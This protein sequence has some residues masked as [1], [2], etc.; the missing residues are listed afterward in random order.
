MAGTQLPSR[1]QKKKGLIV[2]KE[3][4]CHMHGH[5]LQIG[6]ALYYWVF[7]FVFVFGIIYKI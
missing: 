1:H 7:F 5:Q 6:I 2:E 3:T 4:V